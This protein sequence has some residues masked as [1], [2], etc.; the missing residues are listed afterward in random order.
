MKHGRAHK[1]CPLATIKLCGCSFGSIETTP[2]LGKPLMSGDHFAPHAGMHA[3]AHTLRCAKHKTRA[4]NFVPHM[5]LTIFNPLHAKQCR[6][7]CISCRDVPDS[8]FHTIKISVSIDI[9]T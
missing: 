3:S 8:I 7:E 6:L 5:R 9:S 4:T 2:A 1:L